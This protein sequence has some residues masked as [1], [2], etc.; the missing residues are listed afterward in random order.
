MRKRWMSIDSVSWPARASRA[1][2]AVTGAVGG[3]SS[4]LLVGPRTRRRTGPQ[5]ATGHGHHAGAQGSHKVLA[6]PKL[7]GD[8]PDRATLQDAQGGDAG[9]RRIHV[10]D[11]ERDEGELG[12]QAASRQPSDTTLDPSWGFT[13]ELGNLCCGPTIG[14]DRAHESRVCGGEKGGELGKSAGVRIGSGDDLA[15]RPGGGGRAGDNMA[16]RVLIFGY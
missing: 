4:P 7:L 14:K 12:L 5:G 10:G 3:V 11:V 2:P 1:S 16:G 13:Q 8:G 9:E 15:R 6:Q